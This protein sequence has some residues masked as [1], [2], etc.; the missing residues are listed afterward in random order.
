MRQAENILKRKSFHTVKCRV[1]PH[2]RL[3]TSKGVIRIRESALATAKEMIAALRKQGVTDIRRIFFRKGEELIQTNI[4]IL[5]FNQLH[6]PKDVNIGNY[7]F[8]VK[9]HV[10]VPWSASN[11]KNVDTSSAGGNQAEDDRHLPKSVKR[12]RTT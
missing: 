9:T 10:P 4:Y 5:T 7:L 12:T 8:R 6:T 2:E 11:A 1:Y 3:N